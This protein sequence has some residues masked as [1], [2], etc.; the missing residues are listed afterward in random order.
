MARNVHQISVRQPYESTL[1]GE[2]PLANRAQRHFRYQE[3]SR[4]AAHILFLALQ[5]FSIIEPLEYLELPLLLKLVVKRNFQELFQSEDG[6]VVWQNL[7]KSQKIRFQLHLI[8]KDISPK[9]HCED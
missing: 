8:R 5:V 1:V 7:T 2:L 6:N 3:A 9:A 4:L